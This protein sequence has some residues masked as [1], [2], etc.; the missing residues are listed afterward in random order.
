MNT[1]ERWPDP[2][3]MCELA[4]MADEENSTDVLGSYTGMAQDGDDPVQDADDL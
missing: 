3:R 1:S 4:H 2:K